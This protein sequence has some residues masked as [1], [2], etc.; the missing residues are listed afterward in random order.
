MSI[1]YLAEVLAPLKSD[2]KTP[3][4]RPDAD[5]NVSTFVFGVS[6]AW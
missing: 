4:E 1:G 2:T 3:I 6:R 5:G